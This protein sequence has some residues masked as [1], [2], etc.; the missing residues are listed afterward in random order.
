KVQRMEPDDRVLIYISQKRCFAA[1]ATVT[2]SMI[3]DHSPIWEPEGDSTLPFRVGIKPDVILDHNQYIEADHLAPRLDYTKRWV[4]E[5]WF[6]AFQ[7]SLHLISKYDFGLVED[8]MKKLK[9]NRGYSTIYR[10][11]TKQATITRCK[12]EQIPTK[13]ISSDF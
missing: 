8:E 11:K 7:D 5:L 1:T 2:T 12:L 10:P 13:T 9:R 3:E 4:P 6:L